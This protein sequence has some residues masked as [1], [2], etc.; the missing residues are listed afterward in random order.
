VNRCGHGHLACK[1]PINVTVPAEMLLGLDA[2]LAGAFF[3]SSVY[4][5]ILFRPPLKAICE[6]FDPPDMTVSDVDRGRADVGAA[7]ARQVPWSLKGAIQPLYGD[8]LLYAA[9]DDDVPRN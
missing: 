7:A 6:M 1:F 9:S 3:S 4:R 2:P 5:L 8:D